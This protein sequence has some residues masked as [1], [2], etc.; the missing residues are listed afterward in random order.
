MQLTSCTYIC[1][2][3]RA[4]KKIPCDFSPMIPF[5]LGA[6]SSDVITNDHTASYLFMGCNAATVDTTT[7]TK[8]FC[9]CFIILIITYFYYNWA[10]YKL[11]KRQ[12]VA[13]KATYIKLGTEFDV[14][15]NKVGWRRQAQKNNPV[16][17][18]SLITNK[19]YVVQLSRLSNF[20]ATRLIHCGLSISC[21]HANRIWQPYHS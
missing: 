6:K 11:A 20:R 4:T 19:K 8:T 13:W 10:L 14:Q 9:Y 2:A 7:T 15:V 12:A 16:T 3:Q 5:C 18:S 1:V 21:C 17:C